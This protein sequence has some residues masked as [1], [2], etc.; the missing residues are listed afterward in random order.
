MTSCSDLYTLFYSD[1]TNSA[2]QPILIQAT[3]LALMVVGILFALYK[4]NPS[5]RRL[6]I[7]FND[8]MRNLIISALMLLFSPALLSLICYSFVAVS[9][10]PISGDEYTQL[11]TF[12]DSQMNL[13]QNIMV[14]MIREY[15]LRIIQ[16]YG[17]ASIQYVTYSSIGGGII[18]MPHKDMP[19]AI[20]FMD[21][22][23]D[24][25]GAVNGLLLSISIQRMILGILVASSNLFFILLIVSLLIRIIPGL[26]E[27]GDFMFSLTIAVF[28]VLPMLYTLFTF[29][30]AIGGYESS[31]CSD[32]NSV[33]SSQSHPKISFYFLSPLDCYSV[34]FIEI[35]TVYAIFMPNIVYGLTFSFASSFKK[36]FDIFSIG[37]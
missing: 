10:L 11:I 25:I 24:A 6:F 12:G 23:N 1:L 17:P 3:M 18:Y 19:K 35:F 20:L 34:A 9:S 33:F 21:R 22:A 26:R 8:V 30:L 13:L 14:S 37:G 7:L 36:I 5:N 31:F 16:E 28:V 15:R 27:A 4:M 2:N 32:L 29:P